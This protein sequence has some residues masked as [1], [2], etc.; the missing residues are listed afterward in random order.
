[1]TDRP[2]RGEHRACIAVADRSGMTTYSLHLAKG[3]R[4]RAGEEELVSRVIIH[5]LA[6]SCGIDD[7]FSPTLD[8]NEVLEVVCEDSPDLLQRLIDGTVQ[9]VTVHRDGRMVADEPSQAAILSGSFNPLHGGHRELARVASQILCRE[10]VFELSVINVDKPPLDYDEVVRRVQQIVGWSSIILTRA[11][12][13]REKAR[14]FPGCV[15]VIG[16]DT[17]DRLLDAR[18]YGGQ[19]SAMREALAEIRWLGCRFVVAGRVKDGVFR[20]LADVAVPDEF[21]TMFEAI[22]E[23]AF[24]VDISSTDIRAA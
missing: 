15:F 18:Y 4:D 22:P 3:K 5:A 21:R 1:V 6:T 17:A 20:T 11:P 19:E 10:V 7:E 8:S 23:A 9:T 2:K 16:C 12:L 24:R 14:L 13:F